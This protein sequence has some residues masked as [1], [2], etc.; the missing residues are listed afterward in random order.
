MRKN[1]VVNSKVKKER[2]KDEKIASLTAAIEHLSN[3]IVKV[4][5]DVSNLKKEKP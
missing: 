1:I 3:K 5:N 2:D 4:E